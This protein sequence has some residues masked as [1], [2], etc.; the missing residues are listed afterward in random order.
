VVVIAVIVGWLLYE[1]RNVQS[2]TAT[3]LCNEDRAQV[4]AIVAGPQHL[5]FIEAQKSYSQ[6]TNPASPATYQALTGMHSAAGGDVN[7]ILSR[8]YRG[9][10]AIAA[11]GVATI[12]AAEVAFVRGTDAAVSSVL[13]TTQTY[14]DWL[15]SEQSRA[16]ATTYSNATYAMSAAQTRATTAITSDAAARKA[17]ACASQG[18]PPLPRATSG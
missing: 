16:A 4:L 6:L 1:G 5:A 15:S 2:D 11:P 14:G 17:M 7:Y 18:L 8:A 13:G 9:G 3:A 10:A 12:A